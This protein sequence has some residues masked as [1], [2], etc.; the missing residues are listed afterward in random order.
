MMSLKNRITN[1]IVV[2]KKTRTLYKFDSI[3][4]LKQNKTKLPAFLSFSQI[5][6]FPNQDF[7]NHTSLKRNRQRA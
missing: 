2:L 6:I 3:F 7:L 1:Q 5:C 4:A